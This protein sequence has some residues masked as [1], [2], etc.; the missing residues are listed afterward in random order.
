MK[1]QDESDALKKSHWPKCDEIA[2]RLAK[3]GKSAV[4]ALEAAC[5]SRTHHVRSA[6]LRAIYE[7]DVAVG[8]SLSEKMLRDRAYEVRETAAKILGVEV[9]DR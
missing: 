7:I 6:C 9:P 5:A 2:A 3:Y 8:R 4:P 1:F